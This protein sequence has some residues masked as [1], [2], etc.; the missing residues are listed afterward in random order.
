MHALTSSTEIDGTYA[1][2]GMPE[3]T[4]DGDSRFVIERSLVRV[5]FL[6]WQSPRHWTN[7]SGE[8]D[9]ATLSIAVPQSVQPRQSRFLGLF[10]VAVQLLH[11]IQVGRY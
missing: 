3:F 4:A 1:G 11:V 6:R 8:L 10:L 9:I 5:Q 2:P 7:P